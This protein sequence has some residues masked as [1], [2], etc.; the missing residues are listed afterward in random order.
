[1]S[2]LRERYVNEVMPALRKEFGYENVMAIPKVEKIV[3][4]MGLGEA[5]QNAKLVDT[6]S[7]ELG[8]VTGQRA[9]IR[10][11]K[12]SIA[13]FKVRQGMPIGTMV[14]LRGQRMYEF[15]DRLIA[16]ALPRVRDFRGI[17]P[18]GFDGRGNYT[19][20]LRDQLIF[21]EIDY[22]T[23]DKTRGMNVSVVTTAR[24]DEEG[25]KLLQLMGMPF[26]AN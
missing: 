14:T 22:M 18:R 7:D 2:R 16:V 15:L 8:R 20:G 19:L 3:V 1:M 12:K 24:T 23:V 21:P 10:R 13:Q 4:N 11:A 5:T 6:G 25:R 26:R 9:V 17:S